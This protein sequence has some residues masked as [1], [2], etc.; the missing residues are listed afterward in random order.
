MKKFGLT[1]AMATILTIG[2]VY[3]TFNYAQG[4]ATK[5][6]KE[7][8][9]TIDD[10]VTDTTKGTISIDSTYTMKVINKD[11]NNKTGLE[12]TGNFKVKFEASAGVDADVRDYGIVLEMTIAF[13]GN[14]YKE[15]KIFITSGLDEHGKTTLNGDNKINGEYTVNLTSYISLKEYDLPT[16]ADYTNYKTALEGTKI[17]ITIGEKA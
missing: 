10:A 14:T 9:I 2:G 1:I 7:L 6:D 16:Y 4:D 5:A 8:G 15:D 13:I 3:A 17:Q 11:N 12:T